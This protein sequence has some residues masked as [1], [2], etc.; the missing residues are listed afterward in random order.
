M[1]CRKVFPFKQKVLKLKNTK[2]KILKSYFSSDISKTEN[3]LIPKYC[4]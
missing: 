1:E 2:N 3:D 4:T